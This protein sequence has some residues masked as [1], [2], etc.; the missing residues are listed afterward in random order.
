MLRNAVGGG[1]V[2]DFPEKSNTKMYGSTLLVLRGERGGWV[3]NF[4]KKRDYVTLEWPLTNHYHLPTYQTIFFYKLYID[5]L[6]LTV[7]K[8]IP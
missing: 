6:T 7:H 5:S 3:S 4:Q 2:S 1:R 8:A